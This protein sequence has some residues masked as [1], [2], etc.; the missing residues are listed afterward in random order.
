MLYS[1]TV[2]MPTLTVGK[3]DP[4][5]TSYAERIENLVGVASEQMC[6]KV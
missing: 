1:S 6:V 4:Y 2:S 3:E 5:G